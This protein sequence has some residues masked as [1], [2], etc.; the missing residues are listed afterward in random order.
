LNKDYVTTVIAKGGTK[1]D[2][3][4]RH[5]LRNSL[6]PLV[7]IVGPHL[8]GMLMG[9]VMIEYM[10][11]IP[12]MGQSVS[13]DYYIA[14]ISAQNTVIYYHTPIITDVDN[15]VWSVGP[16]HIM[17]GGFNSFS[18]FSNELPVPGQPLAHPA[19]LWHIT[20]PVTEYN[21]DDTPKNLGDNDIMRRNQAVADADGD[22]VKEIALQYTT[23]DDRGD[24][25]YRGFLYSYNAVNGQVEWTYDLK[26]E[27]GGGGVTARDMVAADI[28]GDG[29]QEFILTTNTGWVLAVNGESEAELAAKGLPRIQWR[30]FL[31]VSPG[32]PIIADADNDGFSDVLVP[33]ADGYIH[34]IGKER[35][36]AA[37]DAVTLSTYAQQPGTAQLVIATV[38]TSG[39]PD[40]TPVRL[41]MESLDDD[42]LP[43]AAAA[44]GMVADHKAVI[45]LI[46]P[47]DV[48]EGNY[49]L[50]VYADSVIDRSATYAVARE[51]PPQTH[52]IVFENG[53]VT[54]YSAADLT[55]NGT[56]E[57]E[58]ILFV[59]AGIAYQMPNTVAVHYA[60]DQGIYFGAQLTTKA[61]RSNIEMRSANGPIILDHAVLEASTG[62]NDIVL[63]AGTMLSAQGSRLITKNSG[64]V[65]LSARQGINLAGAEIRTGSIRAAIPDGAEW[66]AADADF[67]G[68]APIVTI[69]E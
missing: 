67:H 7:T 52:A 14:H 2:I 34:I 4:F 16:E 49:V 5:V 18:V 9:T 56:I 48:P 17:S 13:L 68:G 32:V 12:G 45:P 31:G 10:F 63:E 36:L 64:E 33:A 47:S 61:A 54:T 59:P 28:D 8:A 39:M 21:D 44:S 11:G 25:R 42:A 1:R 6:I 27:F 55:A 35:P 15:D 19:K 23:D 43:P 66:N 41:E 38:E 30:V 53:T 20:M 37:V 60:A 26:P 58:G 40:G 65:R 22:G 69:L 29:L 46:V 57:T 62:S 51:A 50:T 24:D 3:I